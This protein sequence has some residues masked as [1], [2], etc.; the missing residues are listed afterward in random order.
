MEQLSPSIKSCGPWPTFWLTSA[1]VFLVLLDTTAVA[2]A[3]SALRAQ[4]SGVSVAALSW[5]L[6]AYTIVYAAL[7]VPAGR[8]ADL[9]GRKRVFMQG[10]VLF[11]R[12]VMPVRHGTRHPG[13]GGRARA[14]GP[15]GSAADAGGTGPGLARFSTRQTSCRR[16][17]VQRRWGIRGGRGSGVRVVG[18]RQRL[19]TLGVPDQSAHGTGRLVAQ[20]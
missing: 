4:F 20:P 15:G 10:L 5:T 17:L 2:A 3:Y 8:W 1:A 16:G 14:S 7:L 11:T 13:A 9:R 18:H 12:G 6:N 19:V